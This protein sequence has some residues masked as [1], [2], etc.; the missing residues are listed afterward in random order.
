MKKYNCITIGGA[1]RDIIFRTDDYCIEIENRKQCYMCFEHGRKI[2]PRETFFS[3]GGGAFNSAVSMVRLGLKV[4][5]IVNVGNHEASLSLLNHMKEEGIDTRYVLRSNK[6]N[7]YRGIT[8]FIVDK[9]KDYAALLYR[10]TND[11]IK[12]SNWGWFNKTEWIYVSSLTGRSE[13]VLKRLEKRLKKSNVKL[14]WNPGSV[15]LKKGYKGLKSLLKLT[16]VLLLND[17]EARDLVCS[18]EDKIQCTIGSM[19]EEIKSWGPKIVVITEGAKGAQVAFDEETVHVGIY[20]TKVV[21]TVGAG[22]AFGSTFVSGLIYGYE[23]EKALNLAS[24]NA[25][26][27][28]S[29]YGA[30]DGL[31]TKIKILSKLKTKK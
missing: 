29:R 17:S 22:D 2:I 21:D 26:S 6:K 24:I 28:V 25:A 31:L 16:T 23:P 7:D 8:T 9:G 3:F 18:K 14:A 13:L 20:K 4:A 10:G 19:I 30:Q 12:I 15:Q 11:K 27:V 1:T 5:C